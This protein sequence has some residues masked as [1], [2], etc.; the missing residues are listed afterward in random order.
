MTTADLPAVNAALNATATVLL[1]TGWR[2]I[3]RRE[4]MAHRA[5]MIAAFL[6]SVAFLLSYVVYHY[7]HGSTRFPG[8]GGVRGVYLTILFTH[9]VLAAAVPVLA[10]VTLWR[11]LTAQYERHYRIARITFPVWLY[12]SVTGVIIYVMLYPIYGAGR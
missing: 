3:R 7:H 10:V 6:V 1:V 2:F 12:V 11:A 9:V 8:T 5:C 4:I